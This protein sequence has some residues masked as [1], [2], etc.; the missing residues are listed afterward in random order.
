MLL[1]LLA[2]IVVVIMLQVRAWRRAKSRQAARRREEA[3][4]PATVYSHEEYYDD[5]PEADEDAQREISRYAREYAPRAGEVES[6]LDVPYPLA[7]D[8]P[9]DDAPTVYQ[10][11][12]RQ[13]PGQ[14]EPRTRQNF[15]RR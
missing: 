5:S 1:F 10:S 14:S 6:D 13:E 8:D 2:C 3:Y 9:N 15:P 7:Q 4:A 12:R 11:P